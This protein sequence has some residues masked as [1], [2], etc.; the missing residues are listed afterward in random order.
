VEDIQRLHV[1]SQGGPL[2]P[3]QSLVT[4]STSFGPNAI[5]RYN[6]FPAASINGQA[7]PGVSTGQALAR[8]ETVAQETLPAGFGFEWTGLALQER[9]A[10]NQTAIVLLMG[11]VFTYLFLVAQYESWSVPVAV[12]LSVSVAVLG[13]L[14]SLALAGI[15]IDVYAQIGLVLLIGLA[16]KN[17]ILIVEFAKTRRE[18]GMSIREAATAGTSQR[19]RPVLMT[20]FASIL[21][22]IPLVIATGAGAG[23]RRSIGMTLFGGLLVGTVIG[24]VLIPVLYV[25]VQSVRERAKTRLFGGSKPD[26]SNAGMRS[27][28]EERQQWPAQ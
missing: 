22:V 20:A 4:V 18:E 11:I 14:A 5:S 6:L 9:Q 8:M 12:M 15:A 28:Q 16:A 3:L 23:S 17:A 21:G 10:G 2:V 24:L 27:I 25:M 1:R 26:G 19:Y 7:A 13:A